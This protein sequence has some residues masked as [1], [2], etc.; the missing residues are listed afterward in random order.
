MRHAFSDAVRY[1]ELR[2][3]G[4]NIAL[5]ALVGVWVE[6]TWPH[7][8]PVLTMGSLGKLVV[9]AALANVCYSAVYVIEIAVR[10][11]EVEPRWLQWRWVLWLTGTVFALVVA[12]Y[13]IADEIYPFVG[14]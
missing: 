6:A 2:R 5:A 4:Y 7:F 12:Q 11:S 13:W 8:R 9:L 14:P 3:L 10:E 1:W